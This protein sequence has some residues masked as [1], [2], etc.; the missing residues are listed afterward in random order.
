VGASSS[1][2]LAGRFIVGQALPCHHTLTVAIIVFFFGSFR[3][4]AALQKTR[5]EP[6]PL[7]KTNLASSGWQNDRKQLVR[8]ISA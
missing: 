7:E 2:R 4:F 1:A 5:R 6:W 3:G 8:L